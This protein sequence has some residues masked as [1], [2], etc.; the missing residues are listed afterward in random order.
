MF[1]TCHE[2]E[3]LGQ[4]VTHAPLTPEPSTGTRGTS[5]LYPIPYGWTLYTEANQDWTK[6]PTC[7]EFRKF[8]NG[9]KGEGTK[10]RGIKEESQ[11]CPR[12]LNEGF[13]VFLVE[14]QTGRCDKDYL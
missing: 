12:T 13:F 5:F 3:I 10:D 1:L 4:I 8:A 6:C 2:L 14:V 9:S 11:H 7:K